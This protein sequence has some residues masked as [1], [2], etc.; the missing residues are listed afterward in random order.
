MITLMTLMRACAPLSNIPSQKSIDNGGALIPLGKVIGMPSSVKSS[1][2][3]P[4]LKKFVK[5]VWKDSREFVSSIG[6]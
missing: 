2:I 4:E 5:G 1:A 3:T 6:T